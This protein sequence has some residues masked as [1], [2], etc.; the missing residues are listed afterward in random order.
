MTTATRAHGTSHTVDVEVRYAE[1]DQMGVVHHANYLVWFE[2]A[3]TA[4]CARTG[5]DYPSIERAGYLILVTGA[6]LRYHRGARYGDRV[7]V[8]VRLDRLDSRGLRFCYE[9]RRDG[10]RLAAGST[11]H[12]WVEA[13]TGRVCRI[14]SPWKEAFAALLR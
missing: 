3:R 2:L 8:E 12:L 1:T 7:Q 4:L 6:E 5:H 10:E 14:P 13:E 9:V 11:S